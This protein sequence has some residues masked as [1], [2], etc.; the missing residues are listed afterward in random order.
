[1]TGPPWNVYLTE[2]DIDI[3]EQHLKDLE[4]E[5]TQLRAE[6]MRLLKMERK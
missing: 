6:F 1:M 2:Q 4:Q 3:L 5:A